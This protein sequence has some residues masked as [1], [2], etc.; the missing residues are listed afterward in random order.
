MRMRLACVA[1]LVTAIAFGGYAQKTKKRAATPVATEIPALTG[2]FLPVESWVGKT[3]VILPKTKIFETYGYELYVTPLLN[4]EKKSGDAAVVLSNHR[5][6]SDVFARHK[7]TVSAVKPSGRGEYL[8][9]FLLDTLDLALYAKTNNGVVEG[10]AIQDDLDSARTR[11]LGKKVYARN[12]CI[13]FYDSVSGQISSVKVSIGE[14]LT[15]ADVVWGKTPMPAKP[16]WVVVQRASGQ[17]GI[18]TCFY[19]W[20]NTVAAKRKSGTAYECDILERNPK[21][22]YQW[23]RTTWETIDSHAIFNGMAAEQVRLSWGDPLKKIRV[24]QSVLSGK[25]SSSVTWVYDGN[26]LLIRNDT[27]CAE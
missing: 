16:L 26:E 7:L 11:W 6:R 22:L 5:L 13:E 19:S 8:V 12:R 10:V 4:A 20:T 14:A 27:L 17:R 15:V 23:D 2:A 3:F 25:P 9:S 1:L 21:D 18:I 24:S